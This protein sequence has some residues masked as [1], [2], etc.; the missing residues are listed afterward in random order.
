MRRI[1]GRKRDAVPEAVESLR[2][3]DIAAPE[4]R[5][6]QFPHQMSGGMKQR[7]V[8][9]IAITGRGGNARPLG[10]AL[11]VFCRCERGFVGA[12][13][14]G[15]IL[16]GVAAFLKVIS[17]WPLRFVSLPSKCIRGRQRRGGRRR[18]RW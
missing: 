13:C 10:S 7:V 6:G 3:V 4:Q 1:G 17:N 9:A 11:I 12:R 8:G 14:D 16:V 5:I 2:R 18:C 15:N